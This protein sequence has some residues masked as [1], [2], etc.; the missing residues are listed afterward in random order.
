MLVQDAFQKLGSVGAHRTRAQQLHDRASY[1]CQWNEGS[2]KAGMHIAHSSLQAV[3][4]ASFQWRR[5]VKPT[6]TSDKA[7]PAHHQD[8]H[9]D[10]TQAA[11]LPIVVSVWRAWS[12]FLQGL[13]THCRENRFCF[14]NPMAVLAHSWIP[15]ALSCPGL[16]RYFAKPSWGGLPG[17][18]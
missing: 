1:G 4:R 12:F 16:V 6:W 5:P 9:E 18:P 10:D 2:R 7:R 14:R 8:T 13:L 15:I 11:R 17:Q 3:L